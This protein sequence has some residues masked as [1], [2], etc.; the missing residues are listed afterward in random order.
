M[1]YK[2]RAMLIAENKRLQAKVAGN[3]K[4]TKKAKKVFFNVANY[5]CTSPHTAN[6]SSH[7]IV[8]HLRGECGCDKKRG[9]ECKAVKNYKG[10]SWANLGSQ[11]NASW[12]DLS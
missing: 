8:R 3:G 6:W 7:K 10:Y 9:F 2:S 11:P 12:K 4:G 1:A 5:P